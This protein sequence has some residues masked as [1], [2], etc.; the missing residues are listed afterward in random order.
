[1]GGEVP[2]RVGASRDAIAAGADEEGGADVAG[3]PALDP[4]LVPGQGG[5]FLGS[6]GG[7]E[8]QGEVGDEKVVRV[9]DGEGGEIG[10]PAQ[11]RKATGA[12]THPQIL[13][14]SPFLRTRP[15]SP[16]GS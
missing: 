12:E 9:P 7:P 11:P 8:Q 3:S 16:S 1:M 14:R 10:S 2:R 5:G 6:G 15:S 13:L 4:E